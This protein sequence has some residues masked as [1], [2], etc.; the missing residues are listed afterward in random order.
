MKNFRKE[1][2]EFCKEWKGVNLKILQNSND[3]DYEATGDNY[4]RSEWQSN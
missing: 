4:S 1:V 3:A 2:R